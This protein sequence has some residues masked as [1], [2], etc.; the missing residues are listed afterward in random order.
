MEDL[1][2]AM[3]N[4][5][6]VEEHPLPSTPNTTGLA[7]K[8]ANS[9]FVN[10]GD[11]SPVTVGMFLSLVDE[12]ANSVSS[13]KPMSPDCVLLIEHHHVINQLSI[14]SRRKQKFKKAVSSAYVKKKQHVDCEPFI[15]T[16]YPLLHKRSSK[17]NAHYLVPK[18]ATYKISVLLPEV[19]KA[20][21][22]PT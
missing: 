6:N 16:H 22:T 18:G 5:I 4:G 14:K 15:T 21:T 8:E 20:H 17:Q 3:D 9:L 11:L 13:N 1:P 10:T 7:W 2:S 19:N 12:G